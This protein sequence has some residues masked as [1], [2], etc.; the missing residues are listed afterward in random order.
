[1]T[2]EEAIKARHSVR[3]YKAQPL[4]EE[5]AKVLEKE[6]EEQNRQG[7]LHIQLIKN[8]PKA[9][10]GKLAKYGKFSNV[11]N[12]LV[13]AGQKAEDLDER[14]GYYDEH[15]VL[16]A[17]TL[18]LNTCWVGLSYSKIPGTYVLEEGEVIKAY[19]A[20]G[21]GETQGVSHKIKTVGKASNASDITP[22]WFRKGVE[23]ALL[24]PTAVNQQKFFFEYVSAR[25]SK[26]AQVIAKRSFSL[27][28]FTQMDL[29][30]AKY[31]FEVGAGKDNFEWA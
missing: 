6:I 23:A 15:L 21:Y 18:G 2:L 7:H 17:Q 19:I 1:M 5:I 25:D 4:A 16:L 8:E 28:G 9:F 24:A 27:I 14:I 12:Y 31:H 30:I 20:I 3:A 26:S 22:S 29:G 10:Q 11:T 13:M